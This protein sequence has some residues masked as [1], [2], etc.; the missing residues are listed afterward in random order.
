MVQKGLGTFLVTE[1]ARF[2]L[3]FKTRQLASYY[4][5]KP[6]SRRRTRQ[7]GQSQTGC[8]AA[9]SLSSLPTMNNEIQVKVK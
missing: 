3:S 7:G 1:N 5:H 8:P 6:S 2:D 4:V 9:G